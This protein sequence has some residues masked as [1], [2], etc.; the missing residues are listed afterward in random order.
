M[1]AASK[2]IVPDELLDQWVI[3]A[4]ESW[5]PGEDV[6][7]VYLY[8]EVSS[9]HFDEGGRQLTLSRVTHSCLRLIKTDKIHKTSRRGHVIGPSEYKR[10]E[11]EIA[12]YLERRRQAAIEVL[13]DRM[14]EDGIPIE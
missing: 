4:L 3:D 10:R 9:E 12:A 6:G 11:E 2:T 13:K 14:D 5:A 7:Y 1:E 8:R